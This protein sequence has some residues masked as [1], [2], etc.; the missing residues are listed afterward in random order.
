MIIAIMLAMLSLF[1]PAMAS[2]LPECPTEDSYQCVY[3][4]ERHGDGYG[5]SFVTLGS[6][7]AYVRILF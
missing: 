7:S 3:H 2:T 4:A 1:G 6:E 5:Q